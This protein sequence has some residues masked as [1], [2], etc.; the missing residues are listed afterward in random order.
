MFNKTFTPLIIVFL[1][2]ALGIFALRSE[3][4]LR[5]FSWQ[6]LS[7]GNLF[8]YVVTIISS[9]MLEKGLEAENTHAFLRNA[10]GGI[11]VKLFSC[12][13]AALIYIVLAGSSLNKRSLFALMMLYLLYTFIELS[14][15]MKQ[16]KRKK[17]G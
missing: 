6:L 14:I 1:L 13:I 2:L 7:G 12:A 9:R 11:M 4:E 3:L 15:I 16:S 17:N 5:G 8:L 10:Y